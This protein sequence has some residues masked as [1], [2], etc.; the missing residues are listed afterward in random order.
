MLYL[1][2]NEVSINRDSRLN[3]GLELVAHL[4]GTAFDE[5][6]ALAVDEAHQLHGVAVVALHYP[7]QGRYDLAKTGRMLCMACA[8]TCYSSDEQRHC[9]AYVFIYGIEYK[10]TLKLAMQQTYVPVQR[11]VFRRCRELYSRDL[12]GLRSAE[13]PARHPLICNKYTNNV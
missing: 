11:Y 6:T 1:S 8:V 7:G 13:D 9:I 3:I 2:L 10:L 12:A 4:E 5:R